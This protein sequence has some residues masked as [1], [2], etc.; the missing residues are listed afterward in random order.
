VEDFFKWDRN[1]HKN[2]LGSGGQ[3][4]IDKM[5]EIGELNSGTKLDY[6]RGLFVQ[7]YRGLK[8]VCHP[9]G[10]AG[11]TTDYLQFPEQNFSVVHFS[12]QASASFTR[13]VKQVAEIILDDKFP[14]PKADEP[15][16]KDNFIFSKDKID[17][18]TGF[19][20]HSR[21]GNI[22]KISIEN[23][24]FIL[25]MSGRTYK[26][27]GI[28]PSLFKVESGSFATF[29]ELDISLPEP[30]LLVKRELGGPVPDEYRKITRATDQ[31]QHLNQ[32]SGSY[33][34]TELDNKISL[35]VQNDQLILDTKFSKGETLQYISVDIFSGRYFDLRFI[36]KNEEVVGLTISDPRVWNLLFEKQA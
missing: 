33:F 34:S 35:S 20:I 30:R 5:L 29:I 32:Y 7:S 12:N 13:I 21:H 22:L 25:R 1:F 2:R 6:A 14:E 3:D 27:Q 26:L 17:Q 8:T 36:R 9:G 31:Q 28:T 24:L 10:W 11:Y 15:T 23:G 19:Y 18:I 16:S 4:L